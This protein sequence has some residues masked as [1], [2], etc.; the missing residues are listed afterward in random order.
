MAHY[1]IGD[2]QGCYTQLMKL[3]SKIA[4][5]FGSDTLWLTGDLVN[6]GPKSLEVLRFAKEHDYCVQTVLGNHDLHLLAVANG[7]AEAR[8]GD[9]LNPILKAADKNV[10]LDWLRAQPLM[11]QQKQHVMVH[12]GLL[13]HWD[14]EMA[15]KYAQ[16]VQN[17][18]TSER[19]DWFLQN[20]Y[21]NKPVKDHGEMTELERLRFTLNV[22]TRMRVINQQHEL[23][24]DFKGEVTEMPE[25]LLPWF[26]AKNPAWN[27]HTIVFGHWSALG[28]H[29]GDNVIAL[30]TGAIWGRTLT[31]INLSDHKRIVQ[32]DASH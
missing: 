12:A 24:L 25:H 3:L 32:V 1:A 17:V 2:V 26:K 15:M 22:M 30:D 21:G 19:F 20:M 11:I 28:L 10:L 18:L 29:I 14:I 7:H 16:Q 5:N 27:D 9:T 4:F 23:D 8:K 31:A 6:R 13:P